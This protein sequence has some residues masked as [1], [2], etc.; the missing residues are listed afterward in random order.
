MKEEIRY[1]LKKK[2]ISRH[3]ASTHGG[4][5]YCPEPPEPP[6]HSPPD[7]LQYLDQGLAGL[8]YDNGPVARTRAISEEENAFG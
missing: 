1:F 2:I 3:F 6:E 8:T 5:A 7:P 4:G